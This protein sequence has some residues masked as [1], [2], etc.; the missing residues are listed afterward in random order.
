MMT[1]DSPKMITDLEMLVGD[2]C[3]DLLDVIERCK[4]ADYLSHQH[5]LFLMDMAIELTE[6]FEEDL[7]SHRRSKA[8]KAGKKA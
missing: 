5:A 2:V 4:E 3:G 1:K 7:E 6:Q 8:Q